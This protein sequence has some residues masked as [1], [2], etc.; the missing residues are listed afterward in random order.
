MKTNNMTQL[1]KEINQKNKYIA[2]LEF[3]IEIYEQKE[4]NNKLL[5]EAN[6]LVKLS[7]KAIIKE[8]K[9]IIIYLSIAL[10]LSI[11]INFI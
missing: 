3:A 1:E 9:R 4:A 7:Y 10:I 5:K 2:S 11:I 6:E 8:L